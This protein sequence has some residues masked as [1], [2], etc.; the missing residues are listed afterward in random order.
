[1]RETQV[2]P[3]KEMC[4]GKKYHELDRMSP[5]FQ[6]IQLA[7]HHNAHLKS[8]VQWPKMRSWRRFPQT[9]TTNIPTQAGISDPRSRMKNLLWISNFTSFD[10]SLCMRQTHT[11]DC[12]NPCTSPTHTTANTAMLNSNDA[13]FVPVKSTALKVALAIQSKWRNMSIAAQLVYNI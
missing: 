3:M 13:S 7:R 2:T 11:T 5:M 1:M 4:K 10:V 8:V 6:P 9:T 12:M